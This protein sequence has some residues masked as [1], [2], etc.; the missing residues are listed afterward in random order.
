MLTKEQRKEAYAKIGRGISRR[1][2]DLL[3]GYDGYYEFHIEGVGPRF[4][5]VRAQLNPPKMKQAK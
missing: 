2:N 4:T 5:K 3:Q 1:K